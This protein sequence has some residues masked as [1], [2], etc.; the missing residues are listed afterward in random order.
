MNKKFLK[1]LYD[2][3]SIKASSINSEEI[4][5][6]L[7]TAKNAGVETYDE[8]VIDRLL[9]NPL[10]MERALLD[11]IIS[12]CNIKLNVDYIGV[13]L[14]DMNAKSYSDA[15]E[16]AIIFD[17][18][19]NFTMISLFICIFSLS[20]DSS[21]ENFSRCFKA[22]VTS[23]D[24]QGRKKT[25]GTN[26]IEENKKMLMLPKNIEDIAM[27]CYWASWT[28]IVGHEIYHILNP[29][30]S[31]NIQNELDADRYGYE[32]LIEMITAQQQGRI[33]KELEV[34][35]EYTY[36][37]PVMM[38]ELFKVIEL[39]KDMCGMSISHLEH[40]SPS[41]RQKMIFDLFDTIIPNS[42]NT[43]D[44][45]D[46]LNHF[47]DAIEYLQTQLHIKYQKGKLDFII[48]ENN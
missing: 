18:L 35:Y 7:D 43:E 31:D 5:Q 12:I 13:L 25:I 20:S 27:D 30:N 6:F 21:N 8:T 37:S 22:Y 38:L 26:N 11:N 28:F 4:E 3:Y 15:D 2:L 1:K 23:L 14:D 39:Y 29:H 16:Y 42:L 10:F 41:T 36:L 17:E 40:P 47:Y 34:Y 46:V 24:L 45:N 44:G 33:P 9:N 19:L 32:I 48:N